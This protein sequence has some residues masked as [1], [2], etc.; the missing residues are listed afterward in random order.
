MG[1]DL[2]IGEGLTATV[3]DDLELIF[4]VGAEHLIGLIDNHVLEAAQRETLWLIGDEI[5]ETSWSSNENITALSDLVELIAARATTIHNTRTKHRAV[6]EATRLVEDLNGKLTVGAND[7]H[8]WLGTKE[9]A[10]VWD[11]SRRVGTL[12]T[13]LLGLAHELGQGGDQ[14]GTSLAGA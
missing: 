11:E 1:F 5:N 13:Q 9:I 3:H 2:G 10:R 4:P 7:E 14:E 12:C 8:E 6:A